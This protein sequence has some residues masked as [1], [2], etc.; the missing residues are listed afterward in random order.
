MPGFGGVSHIGWLFVRGRLRVY[1]GRARCATRVGDA[2]RDRQIMDSCRSS[3]IV[4]QK[5]AQPIATSHR[6]VAAGFRNLA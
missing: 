1:S 3:M 6:L 4:P 5:S 2:E